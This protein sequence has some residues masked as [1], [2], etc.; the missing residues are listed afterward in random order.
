M[1][2]NISINQLLPTLQILPRA[3]KL[4]IARFLLIT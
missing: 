2:T 3:E 4:R 1:E